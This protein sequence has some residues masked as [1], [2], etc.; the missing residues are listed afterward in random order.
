MY[1]MS[2][3]WLC[4]N[5]LEY[6]SDFDTTV[7]F[8]YRWWTSC[9]RSQRIIGSTLSVTLMR[10]CTRS[11]HQIHQ[12]R[13][14]DVCLSHGLEDLYFVTCVAVSA[15]YNI[16]GLNSIYVV[17]GSACIC[18]HFA[19]HSP[20]SSFFTLFHLQDKECVVFP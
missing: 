11:T 19:K 9:L 12:N 18:V 2:T 15:I 10:I 17:P 4:S 16:D 5:C 1:F 14:M 8:F 3:V 7:F 6:C 20:S 13:L